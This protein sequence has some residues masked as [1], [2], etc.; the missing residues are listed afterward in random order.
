M[1][2]RERMITAL[3]HTKEPDQVPIFVEG[4]MGDFLRKS[5]ALYGDS[6]TDD[7]VLVIGGDWTWSKFYGFDAQWLHSSPVNMGPLAGINVGNVTGLSPGQTLDRWGHVD[8]K[9]IYQTGYLNTRELWETWIDAGYFDYEVSADWIRFWEKNY[10]VLLERDLVLVP[11]DVYFEKIRE[12][13]S[14]GNVGYFLR[15]N[16]DYGKVLARRIFAT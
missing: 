4:M 5:D 15:K 7:D 2:A 3:E 8:Q 10:P 11:V 14:F 1:N 9:G 16:R 13:F 12:L 6:I